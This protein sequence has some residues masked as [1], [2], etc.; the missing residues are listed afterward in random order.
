[1]ENSE[2]DLSKDGDDAQPCPVC[3]SRPK[4][5]WDALMSVVENFVAAVIC[6]G[7]LALLYGIFH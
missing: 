1:M 7:V 6:L 2:V 3:G 5:G 4:N